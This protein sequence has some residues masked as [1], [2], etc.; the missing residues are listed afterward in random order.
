MSAY[1]N[2]ISCLYK[3][4]KDTLYKYEAFN[5]FDKLQYSCIVVT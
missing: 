4:Q 5:I 3:G 1:L 2:Q